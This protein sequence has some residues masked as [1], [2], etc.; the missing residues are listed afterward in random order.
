[1]PSP[2]TPFVIYGPQSCGKTR[3]AAALA[4]HFGKTNIVDNGENLKRTQLHANDLVLT[5]VKPPRGLPFIHFKDAMKQ[6][7]LI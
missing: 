1:M 5:C 7:G 3:N 4:K 2:N 6:A